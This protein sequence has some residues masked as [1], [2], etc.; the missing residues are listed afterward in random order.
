MMRVKIGRYR[1]FLPRV[2]AQRWKSTDVG[3]KNVRFQESG[4]PFFPDFASDVAC[5]AVPMDIHP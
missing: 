5:H 3:A 4:T 1:T 2:S